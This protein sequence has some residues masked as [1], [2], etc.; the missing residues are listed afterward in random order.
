[1]E[2]RCGAIGSIISKSTTL[3]PLVRNLM[4]PKEDGWKYMEIDE[5]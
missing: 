2:L 4:N 3:I 5:N 1:M